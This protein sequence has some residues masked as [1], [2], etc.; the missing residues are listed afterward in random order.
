VLIRQSRIARSELAALNRCGRFPA[1]RYRAVLRTA[2]GR[3]HRRHRAA[4]RGAPATIVLLWSLLLSMAAAAQSHDLAIALDAGGAPQHIARLTDGRWVK[5][6]ETLVCAARGVPAER[7]VAGG[8]AA[9]RPS[10]IA[11]ESAEWKALEPAITRVFEQRQREHELA[12]ASL[13]EV[14]I[15][16]ESVYRAADERGLPVIYYFEASR[17]V[18]DPGTAPDEDPKGTL[19]VAVSGWL[20]SAGGTV[21]VLGSKSELGWEQ[22]RPD[23]PPD[24]RPGLLPLGVVAHDSGSIWVMKGRAGDIAWVTAYLAGETGVRTVVDMVRCAR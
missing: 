5:T 7:I 6:T 13:A 11:S 2:A 12:A 4:A 3:G 8:A 15:E 18:P 23:G 16:V 10:R 21:T 22:D 1:A 9:E 14:P 19:R 20:R 24:R 17:R